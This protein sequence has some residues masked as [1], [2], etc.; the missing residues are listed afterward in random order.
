MTVTIIS[1]IILSTWIRLWE[2]P[3]LMQ[4]P[5][6]STKKME[7]FLTGILVFLHALLLSLSLSPFALFH[8]PLPF[9]FPVTVEAE[10]SHGHLG[11]RWGLRSPLYEK[12]KQGVAPL[13]PLCCRRQYFSQS[14]EKRVFRFPASVYQHRSCV[15]GYVP[16]GDRF[17]SRICVGDVRAAPLDSLPSSW[18]RRCSQ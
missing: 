2:F 5:A 17:F 18:H 13:F 14:E 15:G 10:V 8:Q 9:P 4:V 3:L 6:I 11:D 1:I 7:L 16:D 12:R